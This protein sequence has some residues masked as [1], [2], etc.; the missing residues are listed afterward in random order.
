MRTVTSP[1]ALLLS[2][3]DGAVEDGGEGDE[4]GGKQR[5]TSRCLTITTRGSTT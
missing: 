2:Q 1:A 5:T 4:L 3:T